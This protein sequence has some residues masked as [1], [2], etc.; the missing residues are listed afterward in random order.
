MKYWVITSNDDD[1]FDF[2]QAEANDMITAVESVDGGIT[3]VSPFFKK[4]Y[5]KYSKL[6]DKLNKNYDILDDIP[7]IWDSQ[8][9]VNDEI[10][11]KDDILWSKNSVY[12]DNETYCID[13]YNLSD[14]QFNQLILLLEEKCMLLK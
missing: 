3:T 7:D 8:Y 6:W 11:G 4:N 13:I 5:P 12:F 10:L 9:T 2:Q 1:T 14:Y